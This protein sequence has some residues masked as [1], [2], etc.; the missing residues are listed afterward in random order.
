MGLF[1]VN[2]EY[3]IVTP[4]TNINDNDVVL[5]L[6]QVTDGANLAFIMNNSNPEISFMYGKV[7]SNVHKSQ[8]SLKFY[9]PPQIQCTDTFQF[10]RNVP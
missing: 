8:K 5:E 4:D 2:M 3:L 10:H 7:L 1:Q 9:P 6:K